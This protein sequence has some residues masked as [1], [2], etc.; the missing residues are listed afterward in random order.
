MFRLRSPIL[1]RTGELYSVEKQVQ[2]AL[3][4]LGFDVGTSGADGI[5]G[6]KTRAAIVAF[7]KEHGLLPADATIT[8]ELMRELV[9]A[10]AAKSAPPP[11]PVPKD[12]YHPPPEPGPAPK[13]GV[14]GGTIA[15]VVLAVLAIGAGIYA[16]V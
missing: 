7:K 4:A 8:D 3:I 15:V 10:V 12:T 13:A 1:V 6:P 16:V 14:G 9:A 5:D 2:L 11:E